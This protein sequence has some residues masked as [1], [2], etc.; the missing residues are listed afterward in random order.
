MLRGQVEPDHHLPALDAL[1]ELAQREPRELLEGI[2]ALPVE[3]QVMA[4][5]SIYDRVEIHNVVKPGFLRFCHVGG[6]IDPID[7]PLP[8][9]YSERRALTDLGF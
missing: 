6:W 4:L 9:Y 5:L 8:R 7:R 2:Q 3:R 1:E